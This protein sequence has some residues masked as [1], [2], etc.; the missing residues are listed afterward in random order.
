MFEF[1]QSQISLVWLFVFYTIFFAE[2]LKIMEKYFYFQHLHRR[3]YFFKLFVC[4]TKWLCR[5]NDC[6]C[7]VA[8]AA[9]TA[10]GICCL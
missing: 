9:D 10:N 7:P 3:M 6:K 8:G 4:F 1:I 5:R 2:K